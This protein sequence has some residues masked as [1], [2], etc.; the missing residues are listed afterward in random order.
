MLVRRLQALKTT[1][2]EG[3]SGRLRLDSQ[4]GDR[5]WLFDLNNIICRDDASQ[6]T[7]SKRA[8]Y[9]ANAETLIVMVQDEQTG[10]FRS[11]APVHWP[12]GFGD[13]LPDD[14]SRLEPSKC[15]VHFL[16]KQRSIQSGV[17]LVF[18]I[19][20]ADN[21]GN[22]PVG[23]QHL[24]LA[25]VNAL[26]GVVL[27][28]QD[29]FS[30]PNGTVWHINRLAPSDVGLYNVSLQ[31]AVSQQHLSGSP[32]LLEVEGADVSLIC[33]HFLNF[34]PTVFVAGAECEAGQRRDESKLACV[35]CD[36]GFFSKGRTV[37]SCTACLP[38]AHI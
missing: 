22:A 6:Q 30:A 35:A 4:S 12:V 26:S 5:V 13:R 18:E 3:V 2:I 8:G 25:V 1:S 20:L 31:D 34:E 36:A 7:A 11:V 28:R 14:G 21:F 15:A 27:S 10:G 33:C 16:N 37:Q 38:G 29:I 9:C 17:E 32:V 19:L 24:I 23:T